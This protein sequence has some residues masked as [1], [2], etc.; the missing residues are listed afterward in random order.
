MGMNEAPITHEDARRAA[1]V[2]ARFQHD[3]MSSL[4]KSLTS[5]VGRPVHE[6]HGPRGAR[7]AEYQMI[8]AYRRNASFVSRLLQ[9]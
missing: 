8:N 6:D 4:L 9:I 7:S 1:R 3:Q 5:S 2:V